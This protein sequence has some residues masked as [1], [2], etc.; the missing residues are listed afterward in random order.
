MR[1]A[2][3]TFTKCHFRNETNQSNLVTDRDI[4]YAGVALTAHDFDAALNQARASYSDSIGA[5]KVCTFKFYSIV[6]WRRRQD[7]L[8]ST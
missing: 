4:E 5:P 6:V 8:I 3:E 1:N 2:L 7:L